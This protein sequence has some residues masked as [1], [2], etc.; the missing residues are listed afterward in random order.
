M[1]DKSETTDRLL[2][3]LDAINAKL[4]GVKL[5]GFRSCDHATG[6]LLRIILTCG[7]ATMFAIWLLS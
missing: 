7:P 6:F 2:E 5:N 3:K 4:D 1:T